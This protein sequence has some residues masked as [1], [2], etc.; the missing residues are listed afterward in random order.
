MEIAF[1]VR[2]IIIMVNRSTKAFLTPERIGIVISNSPEPLDI[3]SRFMTENLQEKTQ[4]TR[5]K[6]N[7]EFY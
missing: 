6:T 5:N 1:V 2:S 4:Q 7:V 3:P